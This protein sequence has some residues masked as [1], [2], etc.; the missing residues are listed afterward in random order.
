[1]VR[2]KVNRQTRISSIL[3]NART[4]IYATIFEQ[5]LIRRSSHHICAII[6]AGGE[7]MEITTKEY[8][9]LFNA[10]TAAIEKL[11]ELKTA[12]II[13][14]QDAEEI[15]ISKGSTPEKDLQPF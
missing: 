3:M 2:H 13:V 8:T 11:E 5:D 6:S 4:S 15:V 10:V 12:L 7:S 9:L 14:Q 1:M